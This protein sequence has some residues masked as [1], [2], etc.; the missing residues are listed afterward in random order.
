[1]SWRASGLRA[2]ALHRIS[3]VYLALFTVV[4]L[5][6]LLLQPP[7]DFAAWRAWVATPWVS[8]GFCIYIAALL[9][10][11]WVGIRDVLI[12]YVRPLGIRVTLLT[13][14]GLLFIGSGFWALQAVILAHAMT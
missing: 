7:A 6:H 3:A 13:L 8:I 11:A 4:L 14:F 2:W 9:L 1:M 10:H 12:D 5:W